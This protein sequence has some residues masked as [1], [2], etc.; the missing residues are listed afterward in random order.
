V[1][2]GL[3]PCTLS[4]VAYPVCTTNA[5][6]EQRRLLVLDNPSASPPLGALDQHQDVGTQQYRALKLAFQ[7]RAVTGV[8]LTGNYTWSRCVGSNVTAGFNSLGSGYLKP[9]DPSFDDGYCTQDRTHLGNATVGVETPEFSSAVLRA[10]ASDW[11]VSG[12]LSA[13]SGSWLTVT[14]ARDIAAIGITGQRPNKALDNPYGDKS[15]T[16]YLNPAAFAYPAPG[17]LGNLKRASIRGPGYWTVD[18]AISR[19]LS[20]ATQQNVELR[21]EVFNLLNNFNWGDPVTNLD[22]ATFGQIQTQTG[23]PRIVQFGLK[24]G[25]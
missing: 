22:S 3:G 11:R 21:V 16:N 23:D 7:R 25:F 2:L 14:T 19:L 18:L 15:L 6:I 13:R 1:F 10:V 20:F 24:Y 4:G 12:I 8:R 17:T 5:N 9:D